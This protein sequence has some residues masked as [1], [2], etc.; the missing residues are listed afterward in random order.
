MTEVYSGLLA[1]IFTKA[2]PDLTVSFNV[3]A[4]SLKAAAEAPTASP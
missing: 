4:E 3:F 1:P 2:I